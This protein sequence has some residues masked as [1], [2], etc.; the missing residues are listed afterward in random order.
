LRTAL[1]KVHEHRLL[2]RLPALL[3][4][5]ADG[6]A[7]AGDVP[8]A[9]T[10][11]Q[12]AIAA[13]ERTG[14]RWCLPE[15]LRIKGQVAQLGEDEGSHARAEE[16][17]GHALELSRHQ[18]SLSWQLRAASSLARLWAREGRSRKARELVRGVYQAFTEGF[19]TRDLVE[20]GAF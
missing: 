12:Q 20:A 11:I 15:L 17:F 14:I 7:M 4:V 3:G 6:Y 8:E 2:L 10:A 13:S 5:L 19:Q 9:V 18:G 16:A 1:E